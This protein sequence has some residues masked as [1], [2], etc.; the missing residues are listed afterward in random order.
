MLISNGNHFRLARSRRQAATGRHA[1]RAP[2]APGGRG[3]TQPHAHGGSCHDRPPRP[4]DAQRAGRARADPPADGHAAGRAARRGGPRRPHRR[5]RRRALEPARGQPR[6]AGSPRAAAHPQG[7]LPRPAAAP[8]GRRGARD[9][10]A[11]R[12][13]PRAPAGGAGLTEA[14][15]RTLSSLAV[16][17][18]RRYFAG[19]GISLT[20]NWMQMV[21]EVWL[22]VRL[23]GSGVSVGLTAG[24]QFLPILLLGAMGGVLADRHDKRRLL[25]VT[26]TL[27]IVPAVTL[28]ALTATGSIAIWMVYAL[29]LLRGTINA[30]DN[31]ARQAFV[32]ELVGPDRV[33]NAVSLNSVIIHTAR[34]AGPMFAGGLIAV[35]GIAPCFAFN[36]VSFAAMLIAL[37]AMDPAALLT[38]PPAPRRRGQV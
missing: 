26:Q 10:G 3:W 4:V 28:W 19:Q 38:A 27:M 13:H 29:V 9:A 31:P 37:R 15:R 18:Y 33:V 22:V 2:A 36:A 25:M 14:A 7:R 17:N 34:I 35:V 24:L 8:A 11:R 30:V 16:P 23:T 32:M 6:R 20:R 1:H 21:A 12:R 5:S